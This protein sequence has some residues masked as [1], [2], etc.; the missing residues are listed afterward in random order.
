MNTNS[1]KLIRFLPIIALSILFSCTTDDVN[2]ALID[3][4]ASDTNLSEANGV[5]ILT[6]TLNVSATENITIP[7][8]VEGSAN[9]EEDYTISASQFIINKGTTSAE[10]TITSIQDSNVEGVETLDISISPINNV[11]M[12]SVYQINI[13]V[14]DDDSDTDNDGVLD[15]DDNCPEIPGEIDNNGC[16]FLGFLINEVLYDPDADSAG[17]ANGDGTRDAN[18]DEFIE[19]FNSG[20]EFDLSGY[21]ISDADQVRHIFP[22]GTILPVNAVLVV[23]GGGTPTG[24]FGGAIVQTASEGALN[25]TNSGDFMTLSDPSGNIVVTFDIAP[26]SGNPNESYTR[27]PDLTGDFVQ[28]ASVDEANGALFSPGTKINGDS[29]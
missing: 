26:L 18:D 10:I 23:F 19:F 15:A 8:S 29:F 27:N 25:M 12:L 9:S 7:F 2:P 11:I 13:L 6:A 17:D 28:H 4:N 14:L 3:V 22:T 1:F 21:T 16:P 5:I 24:N 20:P